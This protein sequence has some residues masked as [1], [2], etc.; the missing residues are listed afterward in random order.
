[1]ES[2]KIFNTAENT[3]KPVY[4]TPFVTSFSDTDLLEELGP[5]QA[6]NYGGASTNGLNFGS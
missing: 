3:Q 5:A 2:K 1:M 6:D 4:E